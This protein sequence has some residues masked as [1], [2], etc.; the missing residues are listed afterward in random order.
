M[1][2]TV[3]AGAKVTVRTATTPPAIVFVLIPVARQVY[4]P[5]DPAQE[6]SF[7]AA[8][9]VAPGAMEMAVISDGEYTKVHCNPA[10]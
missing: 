7:P 8:V 2:V 5:P 4:K 9:A 1:D 6:M 3:V 10:G